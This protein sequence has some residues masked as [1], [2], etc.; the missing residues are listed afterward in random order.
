MVQ[1]MQINPR[2]H[3]HMMIKSLVILV[4]YFACYYLA[5]FWSSSFFL[6][7]AFALG[8]GFF[9]AEVG[10]SIQHDGNH[11]KFRTLHESSKIAEDL[12]SSIFVS[13]CSDP[14]NQPT[15]I[16]C[17][18]VHALICEQKLLIA[19]PSECKWSLLYCFT[20]FY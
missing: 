12:T 14:C 13:C 2:T 9:A 10:V 4:G 18:F 20:A 16:L 5:F 11:G 6:S 19:A 7:L 1:R 3:S 17:V 8:M 15:Y